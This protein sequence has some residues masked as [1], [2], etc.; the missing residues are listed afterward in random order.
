MHN[1]CN[2]GPVVLLGT[3][4]GGCTYIRPCRHHRITTY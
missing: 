4:P 2:L 1:H 3:I